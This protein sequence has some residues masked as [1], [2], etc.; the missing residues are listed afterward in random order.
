VA[1][2]LGWTFSSAFKL[3]ILQCVISFSG[4]LTLSKEKRE[5]KKKDYQI[6]TLC[7]MHVRTKIDSNSI[8]AKY[9]MATIKFY[10][11]LRQS[12]QLVLHVVNDSFAIKRN[13]RFTPS[14]KTIFDRYYT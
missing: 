7:M 5:R 12:N 4:T 10:H 9:K 11:P 1:I 13:G 2:F 6:Y 14:P 8:I 3:K